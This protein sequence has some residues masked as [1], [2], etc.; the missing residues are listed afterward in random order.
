MF[1]SYLLA[2]FNL[3]QYR[4]MDFD[5]CYFSLSFM[6]L[7]A[8]YAPLHVVLSLRSLRRINLVFL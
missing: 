4:V 7:L 5:Y 3:V 8:W 1:L 6:L 2:V